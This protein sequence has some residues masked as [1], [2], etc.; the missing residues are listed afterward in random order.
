MCTLVICVFAIY[1]VSMCACVRVCVCVCVCMHV[2]TSIYMHVI[3]IRFTSHLQ[4]VPD[5]FVPVIKM[6]FDNIEVKIL[7]CSEER[8]GGWGGVVCL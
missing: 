3:C 5:A 7:T 1:F 8:D 6:E 4:L 2:C